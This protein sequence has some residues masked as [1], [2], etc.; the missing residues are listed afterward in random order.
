MEHPN[1]EHFDENARAALGNAPLRAAMRNATTLFSERRAAA[2]S[3][4]P[5]WEE[6]RQRAARIKREVLGNLHHYLERFA[7]NAENAGAEVHWAQDAR[8]ACEIVGAI[9]ARREA[10]HVVKSKSMTTEEIGLN[11]ALEQ[12]ER[13]P[14][15]T[16]LGE[17]IIQLAGELPSHIIV[18]AIHKTKHDVAELF[19]DK[20]GIEQTEDV[21]ELTRIAREA[22][23]RR[24]VEADLGISGV[25]FGVVETGSILI[26]ENEGNARLTTTLPRTH[27]AV[28]GIEKLVPRFEHLST[29]LRLLPRSGT[30]QHLTSY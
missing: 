17:W 24:F 12:D 10:R 15:E 1:T 4:V 27:I 18:P 11:T 14:V 23:R 13:P 8:E 19:A 26:L 29:F 2:L 9:A 28:M 5:N 16:D 3:E 20:L 22:L 21:E 25:N 6:L 7:I 30:G